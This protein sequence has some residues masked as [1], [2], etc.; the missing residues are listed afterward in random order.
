[1]GVERWRE[2]RFFTL[3]TFDADGFGPD[4][5]VRVVG[6]LHERVGGRC[7]YKREPL[8]GPSVH[9]SPPRAL[10]AGKPGRCEAREMVG[11]RGDRDA[12]LLRGVGD[13]QP[14]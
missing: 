2:A 1:M 12:G 10:P 13:G 11:G 8:R 14:A 5:H 4:P 3:N 9:T 6:L 7:V